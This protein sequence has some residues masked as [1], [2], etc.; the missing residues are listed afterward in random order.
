V[1]WRA[2][3]RTGPSGGSSAPCRRTPSA[4]AGHPRC[5]N[6]S[7]TTREAGDRPRATVKKTFGSWRRALELADLETRPPGGRGSAARRR[8]AA[9]EGTRSRRATPTS[10]CGRTASATAASARGR[11]TRR[12]AG[13]RRSGLRNRCDLSPCPRELSLRAHWG[14]GTAG[15]GWRPGST[16]HPPV[17]RGPSQTRHPHAPLEGSGGRIALPALCPIPGV[18]TCKPR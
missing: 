9:Y 16:R 5:A 10:R 14:T 13:G 6:G 3:T 2:R 7:G 15:G 4:A 1:P 12:G 8:P 17:N 11:G 18:R